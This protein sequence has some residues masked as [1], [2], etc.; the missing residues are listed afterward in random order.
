MVKL[1]KQKVINSN[2]KSSAP[3]KKWRDKKW[4]AAILGSALLFACADKPQA[5]VSSAHPLATQA[6]IEI[7]KKGG[8]AID[9]AIATHLVLS[10]VEPQ[11]SGLGGGGF[12]LSYNKKKN[13]I[14]SWDGRETAPRGTKE[15]V[16]MDSGKPQ[17]FISAVVGGQSVGVPSVLAMFARAH[18]QEGALA[19]HTL[20]Q[21]AIKLAQQGFPI[22]PRLAWWLQ[23]DGFLK[24]THARNLFFDENGKP[25]K[26]GDIV[27]VPAFAQTL[28]IIAQ[29]GIQP[30]YQGAIADDIVKAV[31]GKNNFSKKDLTLY[32]PKIRKNLCGTYRQYK[33]CAMPPPSS[34]A[35]TL[36]QMLTM[37]E[38]FPL[39]QLKPNSLEAR[40]LIAEASRLAYADRARYIA[41]PDFFAVPREKLLSKRYLKKRAQ[42]IKRNKALKKITAGRLMN[43]LPP[44]QDEKPFPSTTHLSVVD[45]QGNGV[46]LTASIEGP[47]GSHIFVKERGFFLNNELTDFSFR[48][49]RNGQKIANRA[50]A[51]KRPLSSM[52]PTLIFTPEG[53]L[54]AVLGSPGGRRIIA[55]VALTTIALIDWQMTM[56]EAINLPHHTALGLANRSGDVIELEPELKHLKTPLEKIGHRVVVKPLISGLHGVRIKNKII[57]GGADPR[58]DGTAMAAP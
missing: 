18:K 10:L 36:L 56:Q 51:G 34:G 53:E 2:I 4:L 25:R 40:H 24:K 22:S 58:R 28:K 27:K 8:N 50:Q 35:L 30:F 39:S 15:N 12:L 45:R 16:F 21:P 32:Q 41:D 47:F 29:K 46:A 7:I 9:A 49:E 33:I 5:V 13:A 6:G 11:S 19:W 48:P 52:T 44:S 14:T 17:N 23:R 26:E 20:F 43:P 42:K 38:S 55:Y 31:G 1:M 54:F 3:Y 57:D 37:L